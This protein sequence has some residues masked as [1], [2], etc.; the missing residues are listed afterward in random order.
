VKFRNVKFCSL[1]V[2]LALLAIPANAATIWSQLWD[3]TPA[4]PSLYNEI[5]IEVGSGSALTL[6]PISNFNTGGAWTSTTLLGDLLADAVSA[7]SLNGNV[8]GNVN[9]FRVNFSSLESVPGTLQ[10]RYYLDGQVES[11]NTWRYDG[12]GQGNDPVSSWRQVENGDFQS[13]AAPEPA[14]LSLIGI[15]LLGFGIVGRRRFQRK[16]AAISK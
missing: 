2:V 1:I 13:S 14:S 10:F 5:Q 11:I 3:S 15:G 9:L 4:F 8:G 6:Q 7:T 16:A 12:T